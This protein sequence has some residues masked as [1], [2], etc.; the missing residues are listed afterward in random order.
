CDRGWLATD[1]AILAEAVHRQSRDD[2][3]EGLTR[4]SEGSADGEDAYSQALWRSVRAK[5]LAARGELGDAERLAR[6]SIVH[7]DK[8]DFLHLRW[9]VYLSAGNVL[10]QTGTR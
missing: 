10:L 6:E 3:A 7:A 4:I 8:T 9:H 2:E 5:V 1:V